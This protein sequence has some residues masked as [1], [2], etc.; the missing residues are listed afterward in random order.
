MAQS[1]HPAQPI[2]PAAPWPGDKNQ[3]LMFDFAY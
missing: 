3:F 2:K 1:S